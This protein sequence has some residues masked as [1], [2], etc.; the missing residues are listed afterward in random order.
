MVTHYWRPVLVSVGA[1]TLLVL[2]G[3]Q[4]HWTWGPWLSAGRRAGPIRALMVAARP[5]R[6]AAALGI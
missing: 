4:A 5:C 1:V 6:T 3:V 2:S